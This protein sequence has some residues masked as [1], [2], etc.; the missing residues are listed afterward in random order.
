MT[1]YCAP[2]VCAAC[3]RPMRPSRARA[4]DHPGTVRFEAR[5]MCSGC[6]RKRH[7]FDVAEGRP[8]TADPGPVTEHI[9]VLRA[10]GW[11]GRGI[12]DASGVSPSQ[13]SAL[14]R[15]TIRVSIRVRDAILAI[16][17]QRAC[18]RTTGDGHV[19]A[20]G[21]RRRIRALLTLGWSHA[22]MKARSGVQTSTVLNQKGTLINASTDAAITA[23]YER[24][25]MTTG[26]SA[27]TRGRA[28]RLGYAPPLAWDDD[29]LDDPDASP[30]GIG[31]KRPA[32][33]VTVEDVEEMADLGL[34][35][36]A[37]APRLGVSRDHLYGCLRKYGR[38][39]LIARIS[40]AA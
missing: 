21:A 15:G 23:M 30:S 33:R 20:I 2:S 7:T 31:W 19:P 9:A 26:P 5:G 40:D 8:R 34:P 37:I 39:D 32:S 13:V 16:T 12:A 25:A 18:S 35:A 6:Y 3:K 14:S 38:G 29:A 27:R 24:L 11:T 1:V 22:E 4:A 36:R 28:R 10:A 17:P